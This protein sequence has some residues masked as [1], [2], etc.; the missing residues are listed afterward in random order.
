MDK[1]KRGGGFI[2]YPTVLGACVMVG[3]LVEQV[4][5]NE[6]ASRKACLGI[7]QGEFAGS[8]SNEVA[9]LVD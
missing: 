3:E 9:D 2:R 4:E 5:R 7:R 6:P 8:F 1:K